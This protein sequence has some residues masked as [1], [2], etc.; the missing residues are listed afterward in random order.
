MHLYDWPLLTCLFT[1]QFKRKK[2]KGRGIK[3]L[4]GNSKRNDQQMRKK[5]REREKIFAK[6]I[7]DEELTAKYTKNSHNSI[8]KKK[9]CLKCTKYLNRHFS[10][11]NLQKANRYT[12]R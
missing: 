1:Y 12:E 4:Q 7:S 8:A 3:G 10:K 11:E 5:L 6:H 2:E 9:Y